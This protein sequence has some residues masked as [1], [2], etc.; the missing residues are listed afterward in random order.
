MID[1]IALQING[2]ASIEANIEKLDRLLGHARQKTESPALVVIPE[3]AFQFGCNGSK[4]LEHAEA[5]G[6]GDM[7]MALASMA[8]RYNIFLVGG[9]M[10]MQSEDA[11]RYYAASL[12][13]SPSGECISRYN[14]MHLFD[15]EVE[16]NT[17][18]Y[19][20]SK[21]TRQGDFIATFDSPW[22][23]VGQSVCY[24]LRFA[25]M[26]DAMMPFNVLV[27]PSAFTKAT[28]QAHWHALLKARS[29]EFQSY[30]VAANQVG[31]HQDGRQTFGHSC[32]Y[33]PWGEL[34]SV[35]EDD[36]GW[37]SAAFDQSRQISIRRRMPLQTHKRE[38][39][40][41]E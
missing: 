26:L 15:V 28:G 32:V 9:T 11:N 33:S 12:V 3:C 36:E 40:Q 5:S 6:Q 25:K 18:S 21:Y 39:Y 24:D 14:K 34:L 4:M 23:K 30:I 35:I 41:F 22:G 13:Y 19:F 2:N 27:V 38:R 7:Q 8:K 29:I 20:E 10:A 1:F 17:Q 31:T 16:D 37:A